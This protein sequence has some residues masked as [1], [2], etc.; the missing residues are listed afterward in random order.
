MGSRFL[1]FFRIHLMQAKR[2][3]IALGLFRLVFFALMVFMLAF[4]IFKGLLT[5]E[6]NPWMVGAVLLFLL[7]FI[8]IRRRD[9]TFLRI[10]FDDCRYILMVQYLVLAVPVL[11]FIIYYQNW[12]ALLVLAIGIFLIPFIDIKLKFKYVNSFIL[13]WI[14]DVLFEWKAG[15]RKTLPLIVLAFISGLG[16][17]SFTGSVPL[18][19]FVLGVI[20]LT[21]FEKGE[22]VQ[23]LLAPELPVGKLILTKFKWHAWIF[24]VLCI[25]L[26]AAF[27]V[28]HIQLW[29]IV[30]VEFILFITLHLYNL[31]LK[32]A[33]YTPNE[34]AAATGPFAAFGAVGIII[35]VL[36]PIV[37]VLMIWLY[38]RAKANLKPYLYDYSQRA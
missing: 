22:P 34:K 11:F 26:I 27:M 25:P 16:F 19:I 6:E 7:L 23:M 37:W 18:S 9:K 21:Y 35:P 4:A 32:Y 15:L 17:S 13:K 31:I 14:P 5:T 12:F 36:L 2:S 20:P 30:A 8:Q 29:Y 38:L 3:V 10:H 1:P 24:T 28:F 33:F